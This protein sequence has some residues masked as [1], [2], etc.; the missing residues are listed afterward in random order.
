MH[1]IRKSALAVITAVAGVS[2][3]AASHASAA[4]LTVDNFEEY[5]NGQDLGGYPGKS[6]SQPWQRFGAVEDDFYAT[7]NSALDGLL[8]GEVPT[9]PATAFVE[10]VLG[11]PT[12]L[13][14]YS[15][16]TVLSRSLNA[17]VSTRAISLSIT[18]GNSTFSSVV[19][20]VETAA[21]TSYTF[22]IN[23]T[24]MVNDDSTDPTTLA[25][26]LSGATAIGFRISDPTGLGSGETIAFDDFTLATPPVAVPE[27][28]TASLLLVGA[29]AAGVRRRRTV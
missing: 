19:P 2:A 5:S 28:A 9:D 22:Q 3:L 20:L 18:N 13:S 4:V 7:F 21:S 10:K 14:A 25:T 15:S 8:G 26:V 11:S 16:A 6:A 12:D 23:P 27:P 24:A 1:H 29:V 17:T